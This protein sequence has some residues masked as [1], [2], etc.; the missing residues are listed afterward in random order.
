MSKLLIS[1]LFVFVFSISHSQDRLK[2]G[3][4]ISNENITKA[5]N[6]TLFYTYFFPKKYED[7]LFN[8]RDSINA[9][10]QYNKNRYYDFQINKNQ[11]KKLPRS[12]LKYISIKIGHIDTLSNLMTHKITLISSSEMYYTL[13]KVSISNIRRLRKIYLKRVKQ[14]NIVKHYLETGDSQG[15]LIGN[16]KIKTSNQADKSIKLV[17]R[18]KCSVKKRRFRKSGINGI[19]EMTIGM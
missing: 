3:F 19:R 7:F 2:T 8:G 9:K 11:V 5:S 4:Q 12:P 17:K 15:N 13:D 10:I 1:I 14:K 6:D 16:K 18:E